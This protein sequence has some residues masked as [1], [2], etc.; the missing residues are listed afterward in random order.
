[1]IAVTLTDVQLRLLR[2]LKLRGWS[3]ELIGWCLS[4]SGAERVDLDPLVE[5]GLVED[6]GGRFTLTDAGRKAYNAQKKGRWF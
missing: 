4:R 2:S 6:E 5:A 3:S 1:M